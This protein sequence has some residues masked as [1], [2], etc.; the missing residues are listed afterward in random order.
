MKLA[1]PINL[2][3]LND[4][5]AG[6]GSKMSFVH[7]PLHSEFNLGFFYIAHKEIGIHTL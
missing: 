4:I 7:H 1:C 2:G 6:L 5:I 3:G